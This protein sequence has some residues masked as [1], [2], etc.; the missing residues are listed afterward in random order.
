[1]L[2]IHLQVTEEE[3]KVWVGLC[4]TKRFISYQK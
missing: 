4:C 3:S 2:W 1:M